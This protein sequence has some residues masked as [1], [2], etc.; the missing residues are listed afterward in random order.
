MNKDQAKTRAFDISEVL[1]RDIQ[2]S[3]APSFSDKLKEEFYSELGVLLDSGLDLRSALDLFCSNLKKKALIQKFNNVQ[4]E[5]VKG[6]ALSRAMQ[7]QGLISDYEFY[8]LEIGEE[9]GKTI[10]ILD[11][12]AL[13]FQNKI[14]QRQLITKA[15]SYPIV[16]T[17]T[18]ILAIVFMLTFVV[19]LFAGIF[20]RMGQDL[21]AITKFILSLSAFFSDHIFTL[22][23]I[24]ALFIITIQLIRKKQWFRSIASSLLLKIPFLGNYILKIQLIRFCNSMAL[25]HSSGVNIVRSLDLLSKMINFYP[26]KTVLP[27]I[28]NEIIKGKRFHETLASYSIF[29]G[30]MIALL[31]VG[32][33][34]NKLDEFFSKIAGQ[35]EKELET[36]SSVL[37]S[38]LEPVILVF[39]GAVVALILIAMYLPLFDLN[40]LF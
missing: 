19:P 1:N 37:G 31:K 14:K 40:R 36:Q 9:S 22:T 27:E 7:K 5:I 16:V 8:S 29:P 28:K 13:Y 17:A 25:L 11:E 32:E 3:F 23:L 34:V 21:P 20:Q 4:T 15:L 35:Y 30:K 10:R 33:E 24:L 26:L 6:I 39:L 38:V 2:L 12:L 18:A